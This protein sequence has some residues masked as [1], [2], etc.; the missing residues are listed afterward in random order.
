M[1]RGNAANCLILLMLYCFTNCVVFACH[2]Y[3]GGHVTLGLKSELL[4]KPIFCC[5]KPHNSQF[6]N[7]YDYGLEQD[8]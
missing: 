6:K 1:T 5:F 7:Y 3:L 2:A 8:T 4:T